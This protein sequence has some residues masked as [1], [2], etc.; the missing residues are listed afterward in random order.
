MYA[1]A[2]RCPETSAKIRLYMHRLIAANFLPLPPS[3]DHT[4][5]DHV[6]GNPLDNRAENLRWQL[7]FVNRW[8]TAR[9]PSESRS[10]DIALPGF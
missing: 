4:H 1:R 9:W 8:V 5:V 2:E 10:S 3:D 7:P 6:S